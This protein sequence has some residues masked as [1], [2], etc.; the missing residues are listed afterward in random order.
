[1]SKPIRV[2]EETHKKLK[3]MADKQGCSIGFIINKLLEKK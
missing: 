2:K 3:A 1:M